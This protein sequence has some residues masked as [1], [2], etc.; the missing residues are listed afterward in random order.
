MIPQILPNIPS[1]RA[2]DKAQKTFNSGSNIASTIGFMEQGNSI[3][4]QDLY[5]DGLALLKG[6]HVYLK[7]K[8]PETSFKEQ[9]A[10]RAAYFELSNH[11]V[12]EVKDHK[13]RVKKSPSIGWLQLFYPGNDS[14]F[15]SLPQIQG[16]NSSWQWYTNGVSMPV[17]RNKIHPYYGTYFPSRYEHL[18]L[19][20]NWLRRYKGPKKTAID[21]GVGCGVLS[22]QMIEHG[23]Q[24]VFAT[25]INP[26][27]IIGMMETMGETKLSR[28]IELDLGALFGKWDK[29]TELIV[30]NPPWLP[31]SHA[32]GSMD[33]AIYYTETLFNDFFTAAKKRLLPEG[34]LIIIFSNLG[35]LANLRTEHPMENELRDGDRFKLERCFKKSVR[36][37]STKTKREQKV[38]SKE[39]VELWV[40][41]HK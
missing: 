10:Y 9:L 6:L 7:K 18:E 35:K 21:V 25:D 39:E 30:F 33:A 15:L 41:A 32:F 27:A 38:R 1:P 8:L 20:D 28:K 22:L 23:F 2:L 36:K 5:S 29:P 17:L 19:F 26:N 11:I 37:A 31:Q 4:I 3:L 16:L 14:F 40:L 13:L 34:K 24:K 12:L